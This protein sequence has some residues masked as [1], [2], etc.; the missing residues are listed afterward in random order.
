M[1]K[2]EKEDREIDKAMKD[3]TKSVQKIKRK[4]WEP[5]RNKYP[6]LYKEEFGSLS[7]IQAEVE[8]MQDKIEELTDQNRQLKDYIREL[9]KM[10]KKKDIELEKKD[11]E[12]TK[13]KEAKRGKNV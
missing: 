4:N 2:E 1:D 9:R 3:F 5:F 12:I 6:E 11:K 7:P 8:K 13:I 10:D